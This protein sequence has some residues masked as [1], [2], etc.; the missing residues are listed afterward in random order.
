M[1]TYKSHETI[2]ILKRQSI[3]FIK[4]HSKQ[5]DFKEIKEILRALGIQWIMKDYAY[6]SDWSIEDYRFLQRYFERIRIEQDVSRRWKMM[7]DYFTTMNHQFN[8]HI[9]K[10]I[11][12]N[13]SRLAIPIQVAKSDDILTLGGL[14]RM[15]AHCALRSYGGWTHAAVGFSRVTPYVTD[16]SLGAESAS[17]EIALNGFFGEMG[18]SLGYACGM[19]ENEPNGPYYESLVRNQS[20]QTGQV[21]LVRNT[22]TNFPLNHTSGNAGFAVAGIIE[23]IPTVDVP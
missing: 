6:L 14:Q 20:S 17:Q 4:E 19:G 22:Y 7:I 5:Y 13:S 8:D 9:C 16:Q 1:L 11:Q 12:L 18:T 23:S 15:M 3:D 10:G 2:A 21:V